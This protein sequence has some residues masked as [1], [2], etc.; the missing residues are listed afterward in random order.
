MSDLNGSIA[1]KQPGSGGRIFNNNILIGLILIIFSI[2]TFI[3]FYYAVMASFSEPKLVFE[4]QLI[5]Y[6]RG[7]TIAAYRRIL[8]NARFMQSFRI[9]ILRTLVGTAVNL[10]IQASMAYSLSR[11]YLP[12]RKFFMVF[13][14]FSMMF[15]PG[16]IPTYLIVNATKLTDTFWAMIIPCAISTWNII[17]LRNFFEA[18]PDSLEESAKIDGANDLRILISIV[19]PLSLPSL[20]TIGLFAA[21]MHWNSFMDAVIYI[22]KTELQVLQVFLR[23]MLIQLQSAYMFGDPLTLTDV[24]SLSLRTA[25]VVVSTIPIIAVY[26][27]IQRHF[28]HGIMVGAVKG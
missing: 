25:S 28:V 1:I 2:I 20:A 8:M 3:P 18:I 17:L 22:T 6:P 27:F 10:T 4:G 13:I 19:L 12:G 7:F 9:T 14:I 15:N 26:P 5:L 16:I 23:D 21:V 11:R 24:S